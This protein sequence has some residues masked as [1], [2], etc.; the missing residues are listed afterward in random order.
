MDQ[1]A[2]CSI[3]SSHLQVLQNKIAASEYLRG[4]WFGIWSETALNQSTI[5][6]F[7]L[8]KLVF[9]TIFRI[10]NGAWENRKIIKKILLNKE[11]FR[12]FANNSI[13]DSVINKNANYFDTIEKFPLTAKQR[14]AVASDEDSTLII[15]GAG[16]GKTSTIIAKIGLLVKSGQCKPNE[17]LAISYTNKSA[18]ELVE[19]VKTTLKIDI[20]VSTF[21]KLG[22]NILAFAEGGKPLLTQFAADPVQKSHHLEAIVK[23]L[24]SDEI[25]QR[26]LLEFIAY[27]RIEDK[28]IWEFSSL[29]DYV[30]W[31]RS[32]NIVSLDGVPKKSY[33]ECLI[34]N[35]LI[36][37]GVPFVYEK[38]YKHPTKTIEFSQY[39][40]DFYLIDSDLYIEHFGI[41]RN[42]KTAPFIDNKTYLASMQWK[43][44]AHSTCKTGLIE[45]FSWEHSEGVLLQ[46]LENKLKNCGCVFN[47]I[48]TSDALKLLNKAGL[49]NGFSE[50][51]AYFLTLY[52][53][54]GNKLTKNVDIKDPKNKREQ[55]F[56]DL[57]YPILAEYEKVNQSN[58]RIDFEDMILRATEAVQSGS[59]KS[60][61]KYILIDEFQDISIGRVNLIKALQRSAKDSAIFAVGDDWQSI[62]RFA[63]S[64]IGVM[65]KFEQFFGSARQV[66]LDTT[67]RF[68]NNAAEVSSAFILKNS[69][70]ITKTL[71]SIST[72]QE[73]SLI[74]HK[75]S[76]AS[77]AEQN[78][79]DGP[80]D[81]ILGEIDRQVESGKTASVFILERYK[82]HLPDSVELN[83][84]QKKFKKLALVKKDQ[85]SAMSIHAA[86]GLEA[87]YVIIGL[88]GGA[89]GF[90]SK[91][92]D[93]SILELV[94]TQ[95]DECPFGEERRLFYVAI[96]RARHKTYLACETGLSQSIFSA[97]VE[98]GDEYKVAIF[99]MDEKKLLC[100]KCKSGSMLLRDGSN[101]QFYGCSNFPHCNHT[102]QTCTKC[103]KGFLI[104]S[105][106]QPCI[107]HLCGYEVSPCPKC[108]MGI[109]KLKSGI[110]GE[111]YGCSNYNDPVIQC[112][113]TE[114]VTNKSALIEKEKH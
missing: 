68:S 106:G 75:S 37:N 86:K 113:Y 34:A 80:L 70:Q 10:D 14:E 82:F 100:P 59:F 108:K 93:D 109:L 83:R 9:L 31:L 25:F 64:D 92:V 15:A 55:C 12:N 66:S 19:R 23:E 42:G 78:I 32:N 18:N 13:I 98:A 6:F 1:V 16:T 35:W 3:K 57:F 97:E 87:D 22:M 5:G 62:Y 95:A 45:T 26:Q 111:F 91:I 48:S 72:D 47:P 58:G 49:V 114:N 29:S 11:S 17:I 27:Y 21:H 61:Y 69:A 54:N 96:T 102:E 20:S 74:M 36:L 39:C 63:G 30:D 90:P 77:N 50:L 79:G 46:N 73:P 67:F 104:K 43:Y 112:K 107:C 65:T 103:R 41:D 99:G 84:L 101:G 8:V 33:Q 105:Y 44:E 110:Y 38:S 7:S 28:Q 40:P 60:S 85:L 76:G 89:W 4:S 52:K 24:K 71:T 53:G 2:D 81:W 94:L 88:R 56:M 51:T